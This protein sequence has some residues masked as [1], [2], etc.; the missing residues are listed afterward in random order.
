MT[1]AVARIAGNRIAVAADTLVIEHGMPLPLSKG[2]IKS[3]L[4]PGDLSVTF[5]N[6]P[7]LAAR[8]LARFSK[9]HP[10]GASFAEAVS[11]FERSSVDTGN[12]YLLAFSG[13]PRIIK[14]ADGR[15]VETAAKTLWIGDAQAHR[16][17]REAE[18]KN[19][20]RTTAGR[21]VN[22]VMFMDEINQSPASD[23]YS[24]M[25]EVAADRSVPTVG[26]FISVVSNRD[27]GFRHSVYSDMLFNWPDGKSDDFV[28]NLNDQ[29]D[30]GASGENSEYAIAQISTS[31]LG[32][33]IV[34][35]YLLKPRKAFLFSG[36]GNG[37]PTE[38]RILNDVPPTE[39]ATHLSESVGFDLQWLLTIMAAAPNRTA[40][41]DR[42]PPRTE[43][44][45][46][47]GFGMLC[48]ANT[49][50]PT[51]ASV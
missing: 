27:P 14:I 16:R 25:R 20:K 41:A 51:T 28:L 49:F 23:L 2:V 40:S 35:F 26:G 18:Q 44:P 6:S 8:D 10:Q 42:W 3:C 37:L 30:F 9:S 1:L 33:N 32:L 29:I 4:L 45:S 7:E 5:C 19:A 46:G 13:A 34:A 48:H 11:F 50:P 38:C 21:A 17:F 47:V 43:G 12:D 31:Y 39:I 15:R 24:A 36:Q 22:A